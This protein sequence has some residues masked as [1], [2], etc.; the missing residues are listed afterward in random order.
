M[1]I[2][3][4]KRRDS[5]LPVNAAVPR[6]ELLYMEHNNA[7]SDYSKFS[8]GPMDSRRPT[9]KSFAAQYI[10]SQEQSLH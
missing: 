6:L 2:K 8:S 4:L 7:L 9:H 10:E 5:P 1:A 3:R